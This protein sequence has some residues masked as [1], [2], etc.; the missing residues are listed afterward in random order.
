MNL[1]NTAKFASISVI[2]FIAACNGHPDSSTD[3]LAPETFSSYPFEITD[4]IGQKF[5]LHAPPKRII[6]FS[7]A[8]TEILFQIQAGNAV[9][10]T[11]TFSDFPSAA[12]TLPKIGDAFNVD[13]EKL[14]LIEP[15]I[16]LADFESIMPKLGKIDAPILIIKPPNTLTGIFNQI[17]LL[18]KITSKNSEAKS[19]VQD[20]Q[21]KMETIDE[22]VESIERGPRVYFELDSLLFTIGP[23]SFTGEIARKLKLINIVLDS[24]GYF[25]QL[26]SELILIRDP[27][28]IV[29]LHGDTDS[30]QQ[31]NERPGWSNLSAVSNKRVYSINPDL[32][33]RPGP[34]IV[35]GIEV[36][37]KLIYPDLFK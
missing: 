12:K 14:V 32:L 18:G 13:L 9:V 4:S 28:V 17:L 1:L 20:M 23:K 22:M 25:P 29:L 33:V 5:L 16:V 7:P 3:Q 30:I 24:E 37:A 21:L 2:L 31:V 11:D 36:L 6:S 26:N 15:D 34:R 8:H 35:D 27:E 10:A 19:L